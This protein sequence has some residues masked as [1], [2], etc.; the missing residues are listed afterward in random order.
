MSPPPSKQAQNSN[1]SE[2]VK[3]NTPI[4]ET[5]TV[6]ETT[7]IQNEDPSTLGDQGSPSVEEQDPTKAKK[8][9]VKT[10]DKTSELQTPKLKRPYDIPSEEGYHTQ[11]IKES[12]QILTTD[13]SEFIDL[14]K[15]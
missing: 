7:S 8:E 12:E 3:G 5:T 4:E 2:Q 9:V 13:A 15:N 6:E 14:N 10:Q 1:D 11:V